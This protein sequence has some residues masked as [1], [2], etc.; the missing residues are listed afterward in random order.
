M[1]SGAEHREDGRR[2]RSGGTDSRRN[3]AQPDGSANGNPS[4]A[5]NRATPLAGRQ[6]RETGQLG[7]VQRQPEHRRRSHE[8]CPDR[9][10]REV[11][12][13]QLPAGRRTESRHA[14][15]RFRLAEQDG[16]RQALRARIA[17]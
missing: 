14:K 4:V 7:L 12:E 10:Q 9:P 17:R 13:H 15:S 5:Q 1:V 2:N 16:G 6:E 8:R 3:H 11:G